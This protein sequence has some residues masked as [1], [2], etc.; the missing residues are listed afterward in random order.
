M[1]AVSEQWPVVMQ[2]Q[3]DRYTNQDAQEVTNE[4]FLINYRLD[5]TKCKLLAYVA[6]KSDKR[7]IRCKTRKGEQNVAECHCLKDI[8]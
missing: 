3:T 4:R 6:F 7:T 1:C 8:S 2:R 5:K